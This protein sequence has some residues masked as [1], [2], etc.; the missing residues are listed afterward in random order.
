MLMAILWATQEELLLLKKYPEVIGHDT[1]AFANST[2]IPWWYSVGFQED[3]QTFIAMWGH[4]ANET[5]PMFNFVL[6]VAFPYIHG[7][8]ILQCIAAQIGDAKN[9]FINT[10]RSMI[11]RGGLYIDF[12]DHLSRKNI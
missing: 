12:P 4:I 10:I 1:K 11:A 3:Y 6:Q 2:G 8:D 7:A 5:Q 9:E